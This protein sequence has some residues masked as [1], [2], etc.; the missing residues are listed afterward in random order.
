MTA[1][2][3]ACCG[4]QMDAVH[5]ASCATETLCMPCDATH[6]VCQFCS[7]APYRA[8]PLRP[9][10]H[11]TSHRSAFVFLIVQHQPIAAEDGG[12]SFYREVCLAAYSMG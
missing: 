12:I 2:H 9:T 5:R 1:K 8:H 3:N 10:W 6:V 11:T 7:T 4:I